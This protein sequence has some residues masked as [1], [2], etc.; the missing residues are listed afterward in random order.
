MEPERGGFL[1]PY[2]D[3]LVYLNISLTTF[4]VAAVIVCAL[5]RAFYGWQVCR[6][7]LWQRVLTEGSQA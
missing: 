4:I 5:N 1:L 3:K 2:L 7:R 6:A